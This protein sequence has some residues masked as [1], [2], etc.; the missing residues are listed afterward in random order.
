MRNILSFCFVLLFF[1]SVIVPVTANQILPYKIS[2]IDHK[3]TVYGING[4]GSKCINFATEFRSSSKTKGKLL[5]ESETRENYLILY[6]VSASFREVP[7]SHSQFGGEIETCL[8]LIKISKD[9]RSISHQIKDLEYV[10]IS[11][12]VSDYTSLDGSFL[13]GNRLYIR[14]SNFVG[15]LNH[16]I[17]FYVD[18]K[19]LDE[20]FISRNT[21]TKANDKRFFVSKYLSLN[22]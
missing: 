3:I 19:H 7:L 5:A 13:N 20:G 18:L 4:T 21:K 9:F 11:K 14:C 22:E 16:A 10:N 15:N 8:I 2:L 12:G 1:T 17:V 6:Q